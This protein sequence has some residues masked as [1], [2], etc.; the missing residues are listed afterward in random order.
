MYNSGNTHTFVYILMNKMVKQ[1]KYNCL[2]DSCM[3]IKKYN[4]LKKC[5]NPVSSRKMCGAVGG[6]AHMTK[7][8]DFENKKTNSLDEKMYRGMPI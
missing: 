7:S 8:E 3:N 2:C 6:G 5:V 4:H 1:E